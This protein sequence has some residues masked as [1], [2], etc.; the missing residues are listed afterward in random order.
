[1]ADNESDYRGVNLKRALLDEVDAFIIKDKTY[2]SAASFV[3][4]AVR[5]RLETLN[6]RF[7]RGA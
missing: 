3:S 4:E 6:Q 2:P 7:N 1:M 5:L